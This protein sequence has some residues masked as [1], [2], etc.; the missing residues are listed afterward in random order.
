MNVVKIIAG[1]IAI[2]LGGFG[3]LNSI[4]LWVPMLVQ[5]HAVTGQSSPKQ[6]V[7]RVAGGVISLALIAGGIAIIA[8]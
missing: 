8:T 6:T 1:I 7:L 4:F 5:G 3:L 2:G